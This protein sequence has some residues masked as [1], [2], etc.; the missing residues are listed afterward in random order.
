MS[1]TIHIKKFAGGAMSPEEYHSK[2]AFPPGATCAAC[3]NRPMIRA[4]IMM[5]LAE[6][7]KNPLVDQMML[8]DPGSFMQ[9]VVHIKQSDGSGKP[10]FRVSV[11]YAC[12]SCRRALEK[13][14]AKA[15]SH[16]IVEINSG[17]DPKN[18]VTA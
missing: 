13:Q 17:P 6:A 14:L 7:R 3:S 2:F 4:I 16:C 8:M 1:K 9:H 15:P 5:E 12:K 11:V 10:Y 18:R